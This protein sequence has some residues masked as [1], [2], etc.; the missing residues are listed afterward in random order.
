MHPNYHRTYQD[1]A[2]PEPCQVKYARR[3]VFWQA[4]FEI[5]DLVSPLAVPHDNQV[6]HFSIISIIF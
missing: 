4:P 3:Q 1:D 5:A 2:F 6:C